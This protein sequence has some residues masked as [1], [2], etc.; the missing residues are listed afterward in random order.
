MKS[1]IIFKPE[2]LYEDG[3]VL[4]SRGPHPIYMEI[5]IILLTSFKISITL[6]FSVKWVSDPRLSTESLWPSCSFFSFERVSLECF[7][8]KIVIFPTHFLVAVV[9]LSKIIQEPAC[10]GKLHVV[11]ALL[12][13]SSCIQPVGNSSLPRLF[14]ECCLGTV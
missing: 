7:L 5:I 12:S 14:H 10:G 3:F 6:L 8:I 2:N 9:L 1:L 11:F 4:W 13:E